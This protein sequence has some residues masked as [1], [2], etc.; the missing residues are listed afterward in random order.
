MCDWCF[1]NEECA[2]RSQLN[3]AKQ[4]EKKLVLLLCELFL[5][6]KKIEQSRWTIVKSE[7]YWKRKKSIENWVKELKNN[8]K[9][10]LNWRIVAFF[11]A[12]AYIQ[13]AAGFSCITTSKHKKI[14]TSI[15]GFTRKYFINIIISYFFVAIF[16]FWCKWNCFGAL[17]LYTYMH[18]LPSN[19]KI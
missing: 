3:K 15:T 16:G 6:C 2:S 18:T 13:R 1:V 11:C 10:V 4:A 14:N 7:K 9:Y 17:C 19:F 12:R 8:K 5:M